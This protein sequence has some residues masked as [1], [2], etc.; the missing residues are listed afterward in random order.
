MNTEML[1][2]YPFGR[3][4][5]GG[6]EVQVEWPHRHD[7]VGR[8]TRESRKT[9]RHQTAA[10]LPSEKIQIV[11]SRDYNVPSDRPVEI[12]RNQRRW[13]PPDRPA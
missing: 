7:V 11:K 13:N 3:Q 8:G 4:D 1:R 2:L 9:L 5:P 10:R 12:P 6:I